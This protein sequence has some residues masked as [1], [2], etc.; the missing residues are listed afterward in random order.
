M[1]NVAGALIVLLG[2]PLS[3][4]LAIMAFVLIYVHQVCGTYI[5]IGV[6]VF[7]FCVFGHDGIQSVKHWMRMRGEK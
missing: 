4:V 1:S 5:L 2:G 3:V 7:W 6:G